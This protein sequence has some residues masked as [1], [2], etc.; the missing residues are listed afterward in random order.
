MLESFGLDAL[1]EET[2][3]LLLRRPNL[4]VEGIAAELSV[5]A[6]RVRQALDQ[7]ADLAL[8]R[9]SLEISGRLR[10]VSPDLGL[11]VLLQ[12]RQADLLRQQQQFA[13]SQAAITQMI[14]RY[15]DAAFATSQTNADQLIGMDAV[16]GR[17][18][19]LALRART[20]VASMMPGGAQDPS[21]IEEAKLIDQQV[22]GQGVSIRTIGLD[23]V[24]NDPD[25]L[26]YAKWLV[27]RGAQVRTTPVLPVR[28]LVYDGEVALLPLDP[29]NTAAGAMQV[30]NPGSLAVITAFFEQVWVSA[31]LVGSAPAKDGH[32]LSPQER[33]LLTLLAD[34]MTDEGAARQL[35][36]SQRTVRRLM[37]D[38]MNRLGARS[39]FEAGLRAAERGW[40]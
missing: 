37:A 38:L 34:G 22:L 18:E 16:Q 33:E 20:E 4:D 39:R 27:E 7:L 36:V 13:E 8:L 9:P 3:K 15:S 21:L 11:Q 17:I 26:A 5:S 2:Y 25:S 19:Q 6:A 14:A 31:T 29:A 32:G 10:P 28:M 23:S 12:Q 24:R 40:L 1:A 35:G 30:S